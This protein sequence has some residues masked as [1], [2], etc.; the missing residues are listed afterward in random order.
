MNNKCCVSWPGL[1]GVRVLE[2]I[3]MN[4]IEDIRQEAEF[5]GKVKE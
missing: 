3:T 4:R 2:Q 5:V 1:R